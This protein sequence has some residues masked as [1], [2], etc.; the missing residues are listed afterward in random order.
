MPPALLPFRIQRLPLRSFPFGSKGF[1][2]T[3][4]TQALKPFRLP[5]LSCDGIVNHCN[6]GCAS[7]S[8]CRHEP[9][10]TWGRE[11]ERETNGSYV[12]HCLQH[13]RTNVCNILKPHVKSKKTCCNILNRQLQHPKKNMLQHLKSTI[14]TSRKICC[15]ISNPLLQH[16]KSTVATPQKPIL[17][18]VQQNM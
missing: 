17:C 8:A 12:N 2:S 15:N 9:C 7:N 10:R 11:M 3:Y 1:H 6:G 16:L 5:P 14:A 18:W 4:P 13:S